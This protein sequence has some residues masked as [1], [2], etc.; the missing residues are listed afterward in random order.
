MVLAVVLM[1][2][3]LRQPLVIWLTAPLAIIGVTVG[4]VIFQVPFEFMA[5]LGCL[6]LVGMLVKNSIV[7]VDQADVEIR[8]GKAGFIAVIDLTFAD[9]KPE[10]YLA[11]CASAGGT[12]AIHTAIMNYSEI[13]GHILPSACLL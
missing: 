12:G 1:F 10:G 9:N 8:G 6:S 2:N 7:L 11:A 3:A 13:G 5:I 4:L